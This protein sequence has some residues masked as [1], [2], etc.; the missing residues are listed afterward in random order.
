MWKELTVEGKAPWQ[1]KADEDK[2]RYQRE[3]DSYVPP[4]ADSSDEKPSAADSGASE[5]GLGKRQRVVTKHFTPVEYRT[6]GSGKPKLKN[7][8]N[9]FVCHGT[10]ELLACDQCPQVYHLACLGLTEVPKG[11]YRCPVICHVEAQGAFL[12]PLVCSVS[13][14]VMCSSFKLFPSLTS[15]MPHIN[16]SHNRIDTAY[17]ASATGAELFHCSGMH[18]RNVN[19]ERPQSGG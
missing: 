10:G 5:N 13:C 19:G 16:D 18:V 7:Y 2:A 9:C 4:G 15:S 6:E 3:M 11:C 8:D 12:G 14:S 1:A 17:I